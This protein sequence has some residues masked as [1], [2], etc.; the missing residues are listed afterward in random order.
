VVVFDNV[1]FPAQSKQYHGATAWIDLVDLVAVASCIANPDT[2]G[3][4]AMGGCWWKGYRRP[5]SEVAQVMGGL[6]SGRDR[7]RRGIS[8]TAAPCLGSN[9]SW[10]RQAAMAQVQ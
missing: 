2:N 3:D 7:G 9:G 1:I 6:Q 5:A 8:L 10:R 4:A